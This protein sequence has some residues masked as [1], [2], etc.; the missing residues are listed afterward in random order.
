MEAPY[1]TKVARY[2]HEDTLW[3]AVTGSEANNLQEVEEE[4]IATDYSDFTYPWDMIENTGE[5]E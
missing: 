3:F 5:E 4:M 1:G 2:A